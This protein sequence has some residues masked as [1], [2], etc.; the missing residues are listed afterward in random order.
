MIPSTTWRW[1]RNGRPV[2]PRDDGNTGSTRAH[3]SSVST[4]ARTMPAASTTTSPKPGNHHPAL[5]RH[6]L[7]VEAVRPIRDE[8][9]KRV[10]KLLL[11]LLPD[12]QERK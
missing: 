9:R 10:Q 11:E 12:A 2:L 5:K 1:S 3:I 6:A 4:A 7:G 8:I